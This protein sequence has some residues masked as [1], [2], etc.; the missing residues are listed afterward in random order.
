M[1][2]VSLSFFGANAAQVL[3]HSME[4]VSLE[5]VDSHSEVLGSNT[6]QNAGSPN[7]GFR[8]FPQPLQAGVWI[9]PR[10]GHDLF[11]QSNLQFIILSCS[12]CDYRRGLHCF[13]WTL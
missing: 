13:Y 12:M 3:V 4:H 1:A 10:S 7:W 8:V 11:H 9:L 2:V 6:G 5:S